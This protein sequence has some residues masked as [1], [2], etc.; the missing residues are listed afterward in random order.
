MKQI[1]IIGCGLI[2]GSFAALIKK[3]HKS[4]QILGIGHR[5]ESL[6]KGIEMN[7]IDEYSADL[8]SNKIQTSDLV[9][10]STPISTILPIIVLQ[11]LLSA[12]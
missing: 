5:K 12:D 10:L 2:G 11:Q 1:T 9:I 4:C 7:L 8:S 3:Y 6:E